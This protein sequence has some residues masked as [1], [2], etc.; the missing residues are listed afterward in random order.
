MS[1]RQQFIICLVAILAITVLALALTAKVAWVTQ[2]DQITF[3][4][5]IQH[6]SV[7]ECRLTP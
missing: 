2:Q 6:H 3:R 4:Q 7:A 1:E 5:C